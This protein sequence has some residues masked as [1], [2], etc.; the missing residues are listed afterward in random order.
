MLSGERMSVSAYGHTG[1]TGTSM[2]IDPERDLYVILLTNR[3]N[4]TR[5]NPRI[6]A[7]RVAVTDAV[8][9]VI[10][11]RRGSVATPESP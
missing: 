5:N 10:D 7:V 2:G 3:V 8:V 1:F 4:P 11:A 9:S 6:T